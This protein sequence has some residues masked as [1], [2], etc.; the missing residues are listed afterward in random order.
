[1]DR[2]L[3][4][5]DDPLLQRALAAAEQAWRRGDLCDAQLLLGLALSRARWRNDP[6][7]MLSASQLLGHVACAA[8]DLEGAYGHHLEVLAQS[9]ALGLAL[10]EASAL[11]NLGLVAAAQGEPA[12]A[13]Q[14]ITAAA[15]RYTALGHAGGAAH[16]HANLEHLAAQWA[17]A[18]SGDDERG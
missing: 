14:L 13:Q 8:G 9:R 1:M 11:H 2:T 12:R 4:T 15:R 6:A 18:T 16:A 10:G 17:Q 3:P 7:G 5:C